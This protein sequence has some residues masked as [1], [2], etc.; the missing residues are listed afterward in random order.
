M[1][2]NKKAAHQWQPT[3]NSSTDSL[4]LSEDFE[5]IQEPFNSNQI[6]FKH[7]IPP[8]DMEEQIQDL[9][10]STSQSEASVPRY[11]ANSQP[12]REALPEDTPKFDFGDLGN[13]QR[14]N[15]YFGLNLK[16]CYLFKSW[17][18]WD[19]KRWAVDD[20]GK[21]KE[22]AKTIS[23]KIYEEITKEKSDKR[24]NLLR[25]QAVKAKQ[26]YAIEAMISLSE[27][28]SPLLPD[29]LD[30]NS[31]LLNVNNGVLNLKTGKLLPHERKY[32]HT[33]LVPVDYD[34]TAECPKWEN[35][36][37][38]ILQDEEG[39]I[40]FDVIDYLQKAI[41]YSLTGE[42]TEH[43]MFFLYG[44]GNNGKSTF[45][46]TV[47]KILGDYANQTSTDT[48]LVKQNGA[49]NNDIAKLKGA[50]LVSAVESEDGKRLAESLIKQ[51]TGGGEISARF[52]H[53]EFFDFIPEFKIFFVTNHK[54]S[55]RGT[56][57]AIWRRIRLIPFN[58][59]IEEDKINRNLVK[60]LEEELPG[61]LNWAV[62]GCLKW[63]QEGLKAPKE[64]QAA[65]KDYSQEMDSISNF[66]DDT[67]IINK[68][69]T[70]QTKFLMEAYKKW[71][72]E[73]SEYQH[74][75]NVVIQKLKE[76]MDARGY[77]LEKAKI[78]NKS[79]GWKGIELNTDMQNAMQEAASTKDP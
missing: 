9:L 34:Q 78:G 60:E 48:F 8:P 5:Q 50:R 7:S 53:R 55:I 4:P 22:Y 42:T 36:L 20:K 28:V 33:K 11:E 14:F 43:C 79:R 49:I 64:V 25:K 57:H 65:T 38:E 62:K 67:L 21:V 41:G 70:V 17:Y 3:N 2:T 27:S 71:C 31:W 32:L 10:D 47:K 61:I 46:E 73:N 16:Y 40:L 58:V 26:K 45:I 54:P 30:S 12:T 35:F 51:I 44:K 72:E 23:M 6:D 1:E 76:W 19:D 18:V 69:A 63:Q 52:L 39:N 75:N 74:K 15:Y 68:S 66:I 59:E 77:F 13:S 24:R 56:D 37:F 29:E